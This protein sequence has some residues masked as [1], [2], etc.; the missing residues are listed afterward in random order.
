MPDMMIIV[1]PAAGKGR[2]LKTA[3]RIHDIL[4]RKDIDVEFAVTEKVTDAERFAERAAA[5]GI[6]KVAV[7]G[8]DGSIN[9]V[10]G[11]LLY[12]GT[13]LGIIPSGR[14]NDLARVFG[15]RSDPLSVSSTLLNGTVKKIDVGRIGERYF[16]T[17]AC[18]GFDSH[19]ARLMH[20]G[21]IPFSGTAAYLIAVIRTLASYRSQQV[22]LEG[23]FGRFEGAVFLAAT[24]NTTTYGG[25]MK[26]APDAVCDDGMFDVCIIKELP[27]PV[28][29]RHFSKIFAGT[30]TSL[31][32]VEIKRTSW[33]SIE[34]EKPQWIFA[35][36][37]PITETP[38][39]MEIVPKALALITAG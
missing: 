8:G 23:D 2:A 18:V 13:A 12:S 30:H 39:R 32:F 3:R 35:D 28:F 19:A 33:L 1:N 36:G 37:E 26:I 20:G 17:V 27:L 10:I 31:P 38:A 24:G 21:G 15:I 5:C 29:F 7:C 4:V 14:G 6:K 25:G 34:S 9:A 16:S 11:P 22:T